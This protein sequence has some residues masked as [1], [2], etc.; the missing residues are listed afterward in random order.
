MNAKK[1][2]SILRFMK[3]ADVLQASPIPVVSVPVAAPAKRLLETTTQKSKPK[4]A[5]NC[6]EVF[7]DTTQDVSS[8]TNGEFAEITQA[9]MRRI[10]Q[11]HVG[12]LQTTS[13]RLSN[14]SGD[15]A[16]LTANEG[17]DGTLQPYVLAKRLSELRYQMAQLQRQGVDESNSLL[18]IAVLHY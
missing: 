1:P 12:K 3:P 10:S 8:L 5:R 6:L 17:I 15:I 14:L 9:Y 4:R 7:G 2:M 18:D 13:E 16:R 11:A